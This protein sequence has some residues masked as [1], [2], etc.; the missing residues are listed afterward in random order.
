M[1]PTVH[2]RSRAPDNQNRGAGHVN[3]T[4]HRSWVGIVPALSPKCAR[5][6]AGARA[7]SLD[8]D[9]YHSAADAAASNTGPGLSSGDAPATGRRQLDPNLPMDRTCYIGVHL[10]GLT[11]GVAL[12][13]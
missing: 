4:G 10:V 6:M 2:G 1:V 5:G 11:I 3:R 9:E 13:N 7:N 8:L 12:A